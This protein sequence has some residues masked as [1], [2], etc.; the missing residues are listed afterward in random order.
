[1]AI[2]DQEPPEHVIAVV[3]NKAT[4]TLM[5]PTFVGIVPAL[6]QK[7]ENTIEEADLTRVPQALT[8]M[9]Q[10]IH[11]DIVLP[12]QLVPHLEGSIQRIGLAKLVQAT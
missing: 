10:S 1:L 7:A 6:G 5:I 2:I 12:V 8:V 3:L 4:R 9:I 11:Q